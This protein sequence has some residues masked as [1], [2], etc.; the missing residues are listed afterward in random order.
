VQAITAFQGN[1]SGVGVPIAVV[2]A[3]AKSAEADPGLRVA[4][5]DPVCLALFRPATEGT[6][7]L[8]QNS[9]RLEI[10]S[11]A[12]VRPKRS[13]Q[14][15]VVENIILQGNIIIGVVEPDGASCGTASIDIV[16][17]AVVETATCLLFFNHGRLISVLRP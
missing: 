5:L 6:T 3:L 15:D 17:K 1:G 13:R 9:V 10:S 8:N 16:E 4:V 7:S 12:I 14:A 2:R 11:A